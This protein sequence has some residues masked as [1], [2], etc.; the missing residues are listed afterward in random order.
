MKRGEVCVESRTKVV[1][2]GEKHS[3]YVLYIYVGCYWQW[4]QTEWSWLAEFVCWHNQQ[5]AV[6]K[7]VLHWAGVHWVTFGAK[8]VVRQAPQYSQ[9]DYKKLTYWSL[10]FICLLLTVLSQGI[11]NIIVFLTSEAC[12]HSGSPFNSCSVQCGFNSCL[13]LVVTGR[14]LAS[15][16][17][18]PHCH[19]IC[20]VQKNNAPHHL[21]SLSL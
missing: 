8:L 7:A 18:F 15:C 12:Y 21:P 5:E 20:T 4:S 1:A 14:N 6:A 2:S 11:G 13:L 16:G 10:H 17:N 3:F 19:G 9:K